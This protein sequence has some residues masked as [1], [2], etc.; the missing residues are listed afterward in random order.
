MKNKISFIPASEDA[1]KYVEC[2]K[3]SKSEVPAWYKKISTDYLKSPKFGQE[4]ELLN[5]SLKLCAP[6]LDSLTAGYVQKT[7]C[8]IYIG[9]DGESLTYTFPTKPDPM[10]VRD[11]IHMEYFND[12]FYRAEFFWRIPWQPK[13][14]KGYSV[15]ITHPLNRLDLPFVT[16]SG[17]IDS[18]RY[19]HSPWGNL[20]FY[21]KR[22][23]EGIIPAGTPMYQIIPIKRESWEGFAEDFSEEETE[24][25]FRLQK[26]KMWGFYKES[27]WNRKEYY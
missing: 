24:K 7:W 15:I 3:P 4:G 16:T 6:F 17:I 9:S 13:V 8:D 22:G 1:A 2:P 27:F 10:G 25:R 18:D 12:E 14:P 5:S 11:T 19:Y 23:F 20:P 21:V 26:T